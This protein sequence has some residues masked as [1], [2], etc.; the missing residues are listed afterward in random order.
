MTAKKSEPDVA[1][2]CR[3]DVKLQS[4]ESVNKMVAICHTAYLRAKENTA[5]LKKAWEI[6]VEE[7]QATIDEDP[8]LPFSETETETDTLKIAKPPAGKN[9]WRTV[10]LSD[11]GINQALCDKL[12]DKAPT[13]ITTL[14][15]LEERR[16]KHG[17]HWAK[18]ITGI[19]VMA[20]TEIEDLVVDYF[21][22]ADH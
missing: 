4:I 15:E 9:A 2:L 20:Q 17:T 22:K 3:R 13:A 21:V 16:T 18:K 8:T 1:A 19:G 12:R 6:K 10:K 11:I 5:T 14:G 7:L